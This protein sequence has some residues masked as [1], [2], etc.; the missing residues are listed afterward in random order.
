MTWMNDRGENSGESR[1][2]E[3][4][5]YYDHSKGDSRITSLT[6]EHTRLETLMSLTQDCVRLSSVRDKSTSNRAER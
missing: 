3:G 1:E 5:R 2:M 4:E 6:T